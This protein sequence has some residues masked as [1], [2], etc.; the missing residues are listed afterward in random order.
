MCRPLDASAVESF[1]Q[2]CRDQV[3]HRIDAPSVLG[4]LKRTV[5]TGFVRSCLED[6]GPSRLAR[7]LGSVVVGP[8]IGPTGDDAPRNRP[9]G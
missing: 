1:I 9:L 3:A 7:R 5:A 8:E 2:R 4:A 6:E